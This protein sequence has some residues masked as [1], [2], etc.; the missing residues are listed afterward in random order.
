MIFIALE[1]KKKQKRNTLNAFLISFSVPLLEKYI[2][3][4]YRTRKL[5]KKNNP[6][7]LRALVKLFV[8][9]VLGG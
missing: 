9:Q 6:V 3:D 8:D 7:M 1:N 5:E 2:N 4:P